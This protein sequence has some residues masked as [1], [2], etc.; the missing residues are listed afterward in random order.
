MLSVPG[1]FLRL[2][3]RLRKPLVDWEAPADR[4]RAM[5]TR[6]ARLFP[7]PPDAAI[8]PVDAGGVPAEWLTPPGASPRPVILYLHGGGWT[9]GWTD[10]H[11]RIVAYI[12]QSSGCRA[13]AVDYRLA[14]EQPFPAALEDCLSAYR[15][16]LDGGTSP[17]D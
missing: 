7:P 11:R 9:L 14:P 5:A 1:Y 4:F 13:L 3:L 8:A 15:W 2:A 12:C 17:R 6:S 16:L 10:L